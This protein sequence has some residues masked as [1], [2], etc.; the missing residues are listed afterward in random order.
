VVIFQGLELSSKTNARLKKLCK[1]GDYVY[2]TEG[3]LVGA[4]IFAHGLTYFNPSLVN[5]FPELIKIFN[6]PNINQ[7]NRIHDAWKPILRATLVSSQIFKILAG[8]SLAFWSLEQIGEKLKVPYLR[9]CFT[10]TIEK[11]VE[12]GTKVI[13]YVTPAMSSKKVRA[14]LGSLVFTV[15]AGA[16]IEFW[17][18]LLTLHQDFAHDV[19][20]NTSIGASSFGMAL[21]A[22]LFYAATDR[23]PGGVDL[24][25]ASFFLGIARTLF[26]HEHRL[27]SLSTFPRLSEPAIS[28]KT[29]LASSAIVALRLQASNRIVSLITGLFGEKGKKTKES[30]TYASD[31]VSMLTIS[32]LVCYAMVQRTL[33]YYINQPFTKTNEFGASVTCGTALMSGYLAWE[34]MFG[35]RPNG[36]KIGEKF[37]RAYLS[38]SVIT[39][40]ISVYSKYFI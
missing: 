12:T 31:N 40:L 30:Y 8:S 6:Y 33:D 32:S 38:G 1:L 27:F 17:R 19:H 5:T 28:Y 16:S 29:L 10:G 39:G 7:N 9:R 14:G 20:L 13:E 2:F 3:I 37:V 11:L 26:K 35:R 34:F 24:P 15:S 21:G 25:L 4:F 22:N 18:R 36:D 23:S